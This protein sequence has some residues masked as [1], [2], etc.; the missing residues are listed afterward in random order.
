MPDRQAHNPARTVLEQKIR[1]RRQ[2]LEEF[3]DYVEAFRRDHNE[4]GTLGLRHLERLV[5]GHCGDGKPLGPV[6]PA[7]ARLLERIFNVSVGELLAPPRQPDRETEIELRQRL[8]VSRQISSTVIAL[9]RDQVNALRQLDRQLGALVAYDEVTTKAAQISSLQSHS[10]SPGVRANLAALLVE[11]SALAGWEALDQFAVG[12]AWEHHENAKVAA[13]EAESPILFAHAL[14][15]QAVI[16]IDSGEPQAA[17]AQVAQAREMI[18]RSAP[19]IFQSWLAAAH[20][21]AL[22]AAGERS[23]A[24]RAFDMADSLL[25]SDPFDPELPFLFLGGPHLDR[26][27][28]HA[29]AQLGDRDAISVLANA[30]TRLDPSFIRAET[31]LRVDLATALLATGERD[32]AKAHAT[33]AADLAYD[34]GSARQARRVHALSGFLGSFG[35]KP[36]S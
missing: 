11:L 24:L 6:R 18:R 7:T 19:T 32:E 21:E 30:L 36:K 15:Q 20:G 3:V 17:I 29:L 27:R 34:I 9:L 10:L 2:T 4:T 8:S 12:R 26:W 13:R 1:E 31:A 33:V 14:A 23:D 5:S 22:A 35:L 25:P 16:L 28:G